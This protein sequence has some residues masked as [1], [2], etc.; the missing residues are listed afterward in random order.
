MAKSHELNIISEHSRIGRGNLND[1]IQISSTCDTYLN[2]KNIN[3]LLIIRYWKASKNAFQ[4]NKYY[5]VQGGSIVH[6]PI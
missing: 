4:R 5:P 1:K 2:K 6:K 3:P